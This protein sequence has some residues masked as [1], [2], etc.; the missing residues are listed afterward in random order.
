MEK[1]LYSWYIDYHDKNKKPVTAKLIKQKALEFTDRKDF[2]ASK[3][4][5][6]KYKKKYNLYISK[7]SELK[8]K[9]KN[10]I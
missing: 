7:E 8:N 3:G 9:E 1:K 10:Q 2:H 4:W 6:E 5:L